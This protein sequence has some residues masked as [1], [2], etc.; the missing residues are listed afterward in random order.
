[1]GERAWWRV[2]ASSV[3]LVACGGDPA[4]SD[5]G[6]DAG[7]RDAAA[8]S[9]I[10]PAS[11]AMTPCPPGW[12]DIDVAGVVACDPWPATGRRDDCGPDEAHFPGTDG[13]AR[14]IL[15]AL[16]P[17]GAARPLGIAL[18][19]AIAAALVLRHA[20][21]AITFERLLARQ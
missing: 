5:A 15:S 1:M 16:L 17:G 11:P 7:A 19:Y 21:R 14:I 20:L 3:L 4:A 9:P 8:Y 12:R 10:P 13:C 18:V 2:F 6:R